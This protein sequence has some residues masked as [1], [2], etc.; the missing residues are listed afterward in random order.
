LQKAASQVSSEVGF[1]NAVVANSGIDGPT[2]KGL[3]DKPSV[4]ELQQFLWKVPISDFTNTFL[5]NT[6]SA[7]YTCIAFLKLLDNG[8]SHKASPGSTLGIRS[9]FIVTSSIAGYNR[10][11]TAG[12]AYGTSKAATVHLM[13][14]LAYYLAPYRIRSNVIAPGLYISEMTQVTSFP[15]SNFEDKKLTSLGPFSR[16]RC[17][18]RRLYSCKRSSTD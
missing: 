15:L 9:Q 12:F 4:D 10:K 1:V 14:M 17:N 7:F 18:T 13:K 3:S 2:L 6:S 8:N 11:A 16:I 5:V